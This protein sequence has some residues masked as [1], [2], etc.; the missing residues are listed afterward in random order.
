MEKICR[1]SDQFL[2]FVYVLGLSKTGLIFTRSLEGTQPSRLTQTG[3][4]E[5]VF[6]TV[7]RHAQ[8]WGGSWLGGSQ[9]WLGSA[10]GT[11]RWEFLCAFYCLFSIFL[12]SV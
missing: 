11:R 3:H 9:S 7:C 10:L 8:F 6:D 5:W 4:T 1:I 12:L 2:P